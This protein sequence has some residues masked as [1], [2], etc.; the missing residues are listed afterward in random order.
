MKLPSPIR[1]LIADDHPIIR[2]GLRIIIAMQKDMEIVGEAATG[3]EALT[4]Y[5]ALKPDVILLDLRMPGKDGF[6]AAEEIIES[7]PGARI[8]II[9]TYDGDENI[10]R[11]LKAGAKAY[12]LKDAP[13]QEIWNTIRIVHS[14]KSSLPPA[15]AAKIAE[16]FSKP[17]LSLRQKEVLQLIAT[18]KSNKEIGLKLDISEGTVKAHVKS[19]LSKLEALS[20]TEAIAIASRRGLVS[21]T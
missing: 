8:I 9:T 17:E 20:R 21:L 6:Q 3:E 11:S 18:G 10:R 7:D 2:E 13:R 16:N 14:G 15:I 19:V 1:I 12:L 5:A 4:L